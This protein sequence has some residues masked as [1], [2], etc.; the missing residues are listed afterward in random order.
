[1]PW[2]TD[3]SQQREI[4]KTKY[5]NTDKEREGG[6]GLANISWKRK[7]AFP[8]ATTLKEITNHSGMM[9]NQGILPLN[10]NIGE[11]SDMFKIMFTT[12]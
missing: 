5:Y 7:S 12:K 11:R 3:H 6:S 4:C 10:K 8:R 1:M 9:E 2:I